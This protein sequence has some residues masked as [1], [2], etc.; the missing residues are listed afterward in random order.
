MNYVAHFFGGLKLDD[1]ERLE[2]LN[3]LNRN[4]FNFK[5]DRTL[6]QIYEAENKYKDINECNHG[7]SKKNHKDNHRDILKMSMMKI[8]EIMKGQMIDE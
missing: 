6:I 8:L 5:E 7:E 1:F 3:K 4:L 2:N